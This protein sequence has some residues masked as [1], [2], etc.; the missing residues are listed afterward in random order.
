[1]FNIN[2]NIRKRPWRSRTHASEH[3]RWYTL[4]R[5][6]EARP[7]LASGPHGHSH[8]RTARTGLWLRGWLLQGRRQ[9]LVASLHFCIYFSDFEK[10]H[11]RHDEFQNQA[12]D[13]NERLQMK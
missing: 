13:R 8:T 6:E 10:L 9:T 3:T 2:T 11:L 5:K 7:D 4:K 1:M 12:N